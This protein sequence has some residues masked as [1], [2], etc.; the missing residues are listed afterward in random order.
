MPDRTAFLDR[1]RSSVEAGVQTGPSVL[2]LHGGAISGEHGIGIGKGTLMDAAH[3]PAL[4]LMR[5]IKEALDPDN[6]FNPGKVL[7]E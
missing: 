5:A 6:I 1:L 7:P 4:D 3:G 2:D